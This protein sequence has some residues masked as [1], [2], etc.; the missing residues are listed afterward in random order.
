MPSVNAQEVNS[1]TVT[2]SAG[3]GECCQVFDVV[4]DH[5]LSEIPSTT[6]AG[7]HFMLSIHSIF[8]CLVLLMNAVQTLPIRWY[9]L[10]AF[11]GDMLQLG[12][13]VLFAIGLI[14]ACLAKQS[15]R[16]IVSHDQ[17]IKIPQSQTESSKNTYIMSMSRRFFL[18][19]YMAGRHGH[20]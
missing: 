5:H 14:Y 11:R 10:L 16:H 18:S 20:S 17:E 15:S 12:I 9:H 3:T 2:P 1:S 8:L 4:L 19:C 6:C 13:Y 7:T